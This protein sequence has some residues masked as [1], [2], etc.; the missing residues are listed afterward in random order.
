[1][2]LKYA[3]TLTLYQAGAGN[4]IGATTVVLTS[5]ADIYGNVLTMTDFGTKGYI[6][7]EPD[8]SNEEGATFTGITANANGTYSLTGVSTILAKSPYTE[9]SGLVRQHSGGSKVVVT[10]NVAFWNTFANTQNTN[11]FTVLPQSAATPSANADFVTKVYADGLA[12][13]GAPNASLTVKGIVQESTQAQTDAR[14]AAG[15]TGAEL[16]VNPATLRSTQTSDYVATD[17]GSANTYAIAPAPVFTAYVAGQRFIFKV[18][19]TNTSVS[20]LNVN[21]LGTKTIKKYGSFDVGPGDLIAGTIVEVIYDGTNMQVISPLGGTPIG[22]VSPYVASLVPGG[23]IVCDGSA[24]SRTT[25]A[26]LFAV[27]SP[28]Q[29]FT[30]TLASPAVFSAT[31][32]GLQIGDKIRLTTTGA[33]PTGLATATDYFV[34]SAGFGANSF[35]VS[36]SRGGAAVNTSVSQSGTHTMRFSNWGVGDGS[37]TFNVPDLRGFTIYGQKTSDTNFDNLNT[38]TVYAGEKTHVLSVGELPAHHHSV[39]FT[40]SGGSGGNVIGTVGASNDQVT[41][42]TGSGTAHNNM[43]PYVVMQ[44]IIKV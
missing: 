38:P 32:H 34:I 6:T 13:A 9:T 22:T 23:W 2:S 44:Y 21:A 26:A 42:D 14:T 3:Q 17:T 5:L 10:D 28:A 27:I 30:V 37:T 4:I 29:T 33:L 39:N 20:T 11:T 35:E 18:A 31:A 12:I 43:P 41:G 19:N 7:L 24:I 16:Y 1:M 40:L 25:Y 15:S 8:T 36:A